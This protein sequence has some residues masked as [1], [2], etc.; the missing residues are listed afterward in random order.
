MKPSSFYGQTLPLG[1][2]ESYTPENVAKLTIEQALADYAAV[3][4]YVKARWS[5]PETQPLIAFGGSYPGTPHARWNLSHLS[6]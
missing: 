3:I 6:L 4:N 2:Q 5:L 1:P